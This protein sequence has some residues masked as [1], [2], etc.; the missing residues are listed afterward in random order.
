MTFRDAVIERLQAEFGQPEVSPVRSGNLYRWTLHRGPY[1]VSMFITIDSPE[2]EDIA[3]IMIS[4]GARHQ[5]EPV[6]ALTVR[7]MPE[8]EKLIEQIKLQWKGPSGA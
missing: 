5:I 8:T 7:T 4:D 3:H 6:V 1:G 2:F